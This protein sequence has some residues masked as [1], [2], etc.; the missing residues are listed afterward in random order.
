MKIIDADPVRMIDLPGVGPCPRPVDI[1][2]RVTGFQRVKSLRIYRFQPGLAIHG[3]SEVD[4]VFILPLS[5]SFDMQISGAHPLSAR[6]SATGPTRALYMTPGHSYVLTPQGPVTVAYARAGA[7]G[8]VPCQT[9]ST[10]DGAGV[11]EHLRCRLV[12][13]ITGQTLS[14]GGGGECLVHVA[15]G[16]L[17][18]SDQTIAMGQTL[19]LSEAVMLRAKCD[20]RLLIIG[21]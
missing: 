5:G 16:A 1:D 3:D 4:E 15:D 17:D 2:Q 11:A 20:A 7:Q 13:L 6:V 8:R 14:L 21:V 10:I 19:A 12:D 9:L 18:L